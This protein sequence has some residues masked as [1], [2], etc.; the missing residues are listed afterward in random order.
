MILVGNG[1]NVP[2]VE[3]VPL[4]L[5]PTAADGDPVATR[6]PLIACGCLV[7]PIAGLWALGS[8]GDGAKGMRAREFVR[9][10]ASTLFIVYVPLPGPFHLGG[11]PYCGIGRAVSRLASHKS[12]GIGESRE[13]Q[14]QALLHVPALPEMVLKV[15]GVL[16]AI[17]LLS[18]VIVLSNRRVTRGRAEYRR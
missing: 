2:Y 18:A 17:H 16:A 14:L 8:I 9:H 7:G 4:T 1:M 3:R 6:Y 10:A 11:V 5:Q 13:R 12:L 15:L